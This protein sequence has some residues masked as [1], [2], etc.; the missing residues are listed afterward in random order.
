MSKTDPF[1]TLQNIK[2]NWINLADN[3]KSIG[4]KERAY[5]ILKDLFRYQNDSSPAILSE[6]YLRHL[7]DWQQFSCL[8][9]ATT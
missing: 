6:L 3:Y 7:H 5:E 8:R 9:H 4:Q 1:Q 2:I